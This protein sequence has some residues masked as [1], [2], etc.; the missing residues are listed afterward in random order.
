MKKL[1]LF[2]FLTSCSSINSNYNNNVV[3][4][5]DK[6]LTFN[7]FKNLLTIYSES[8]PYQDIDK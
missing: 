2:L 6:D 8:S 5:F 1:F 4:D 7:E 3:L